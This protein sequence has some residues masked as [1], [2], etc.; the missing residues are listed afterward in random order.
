MCMVLKCFWLY[1]HGVRSTP[2]QSYSHFFC[3][4]CIVT[5]FR[6]HTKFIFDPMLVK[7][8]WDQ[9]VVV[10]LKNCKQT[11]EDANEFLYTYV[12]KCSHPTKETITKLQFWDPWFL[13]LGFEF[14]NNF[15]LPVNSGHFETPVNQFW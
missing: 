9:E 3:K 8:K 4:F 6:I 2:F 12:Q 11:A 15:E 10:N 13:L 1:Q 7:P 5:F 14:L